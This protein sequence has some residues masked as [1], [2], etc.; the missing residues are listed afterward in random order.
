LY[1]GCWRDD[2]D[3]PKGVKHQ[4]VGVVGNKD[5]GLPLTA[6]SR[7][8]SSVGS[9]HAVMRSPVRKKDLFNGDI[10]SSRP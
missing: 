7:N 4:Q 10:G 9:R 2:G 5:I 3:R 6:S 1:E 8:R